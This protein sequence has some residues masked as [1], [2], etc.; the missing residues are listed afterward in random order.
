MG[1][2]EVALAKKNS[3]SCQPCTTVG[4]QEHKTK[5]CYIKSFKNNIVE[6]SPPH[7]WP[8]FFPHCVNQ[9][10]PAQVQSCRE[11]GCVSKKNLSF[12]QW[13]SGHISGQFQPEEPSLWCCLDLRHSQC[14]SGEDSGLLRSPDCQHASELLEGCSLTEACFLALIQKVCIFR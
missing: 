14:L 9:H 10:V 3:L 12:P 6:R 7:C 13:R 11:K 4:S 8:V 5:G 2:P 1:L